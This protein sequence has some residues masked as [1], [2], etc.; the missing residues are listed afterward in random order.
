MQNKNGNYEKP[1]LIA[2]A[3]FA[4]LG[5][6]YF[7]YD[8]MG[9][10]E[11]LTLQTAKSANN[12]SPPPTEGVKQIIARLVEKITWVAPIIKDKPVPLNKSVTLIQ[13][14]DQIFDIR[15]ADPVL[16]PPMTNE[17]LVKYELPNIES[18]NVGALDP[19]GDGFTNEEE[20]SAA[21]QTHPR[22]AASHPPVTNKLFLARR[23]T[24][25]Y[26][27]RLNNSSA[28]YQVQRLAP[29][30]KV[31]K[32]VSPGDEF[33]FDRGVNRFKVLTYEVKKEKDANTGLEKDLSELKCLD[34]ATNREFSLLRGKEVNLA[35]YEAEFEFRIG[36]AERRTVKSGETFQIPGIGQTFK[37]LSIEE[38]Q[39]T[40]V[41]V[42][43]GDPIVVKKG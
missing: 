11:R 33:G 31:S 37:V 41:P 39:A 32:F 22:D 15:V 14:G 34:V 7:I 30:P 28:P 16:R 43:G 21:P 1:L 27:M 38:E 5:V 20:F 24:K 18:P 35:D 6:G 26:K 40:I 9:L 29:E 10:S 19:D 42:D 8:G 17:F 12:P 25:D 23:I 36:E 4:M 13:K 2:S 3:V